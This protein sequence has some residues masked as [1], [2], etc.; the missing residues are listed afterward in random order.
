M[1]NKVL[2]QFV[3]KLKKEYAVGVRCSWEGKPFAEILRKTI[4]RQDALKKIYELMRWKDFFFAYTITDNKLQK[5]DVPQ[6]SENNMRKFMIGP[7]ADLNPFTERK[8]IDKEIETIRERLV[9]WNKKR[10]YILERINT[11]SHLIII[12]TNSSLKHRPHNPISALN[13]PK[14]EHFII[15]VIKIK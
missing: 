6:S 12:K 11:A 3:K 13:P 2:V 5:H 10:H 9:C 8:R 7:I 1:K 14:R 4:A 15:E